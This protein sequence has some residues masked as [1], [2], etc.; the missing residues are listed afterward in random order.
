ME[1]QFCHCRNANHKGDWWTYEWPG[2][3][4]APFLQKQSLCPTVIFAFGQSVPLKTWA[5]YSTSLPLCFLICRMEIRRAPVLPHQ[6]LWRLDNGCKVKG[7]SIITNKEIS[8]QMKKNLR[9]P[10]KVYCSILFESIWAVC[11]PIH[12]VWLSCKKL[13]VNV[14]PFYLFTRLKK[15]FDNEHLY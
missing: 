1:I 6:D 10:P 4:P 11:G 12:S 9:D 15:L 5:C 7:I 8:Q 13:G 14:W 2:E 3:Y